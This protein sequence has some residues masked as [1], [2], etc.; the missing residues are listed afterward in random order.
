MCFHVDTLDQIRAHF[1]NLQPAKRAVEKFPVS[2]FHLE[3]ASSSTESSTQSS[4]HSDELESQ[5]SLLGEGDETP[6]FCSAYLRGTAAK[7]LL[8]FTMLWLSGM[9]I[10]MLVLKLNRHTI[11][12]CLH[13]C[14]FGFILVLMASYEVKRRESKHIETEKLPSWA[15]FA[16]PHFVWLI[17]CQSSR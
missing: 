4:T 8:A 3:M 1:A 14:S 11:L 2:P 6:R 10:T 13:G 9:S 5:E 16:L 7:C 12:R 15:V 17:L